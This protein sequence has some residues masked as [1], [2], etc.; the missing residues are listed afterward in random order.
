MKFRITL[1]FLAV[2]LIQTLI[3]VIWLGKLPRINTQ[4]ER[5]PIPTLIPAELAAPTRQV[6]QISFG[7]GACQ[8]RALDIIGAWVKASKPETVP[9]DFNDVNGVQCQATFPKEVLPLFN[10]PNIWFDGAITCSSCHGVD[11]SQSAAR[12]SLTSY[13]DILAGSQRPS[14]GQPGND[15]LDNTDG[16]EKSRLY[17]M[18]STR[19]MPIGRPSNSDPKGPLIWVGVVKK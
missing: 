6:E 17:V 8:V 15:I 3:L 9:F 7:G 4:P 1:A 12:M 16:W 14:A 11:I 19:Q 10:Q 13:Q 5:T 18:I 2:F